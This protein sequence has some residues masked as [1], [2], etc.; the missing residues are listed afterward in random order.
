MMNSKKVFTS[1]VVFL[2]A[3]LVFLFTASPVLAQN[4]GGIIGKMRG[5]LRSMED[6]GDAGGGEAGGGKGDGGNLKKDK[7]KPKKVLASSTDQD[8]NTTT[9]SDGGD[10]VQI[11]DVTDKDGKPIS[12]TRKKK[13]DSGDEWID[14]T[15]HTTGK[16]TKTLVGKDGQ[17]IFSDTY[18]SV[19]RD[20]DGNITGWTKNDDRGRETE[21]LWQDDN[22]NTYYVDRDPDT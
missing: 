19:M 15:D 6:G 4:G 13:D 12:T 3:G 9:V 5:V 1:T 21:S 7:D 17:T 2:L 22:G 11:I 18:D 10:G 8:G 20:D 14:V 16:V